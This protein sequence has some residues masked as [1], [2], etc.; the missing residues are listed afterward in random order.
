MGEEPKKK[1]KDTFSMRRYIDYALIVF[2]LFCCCI[3]F[4]FAVYRYRGI[5]AAMGKIMGAL[6]PIIFGLVIAYLINPIMMFVERHVL[7]LLQNKFSTRKKEQKAARVIGTVCAIVIF[8]LIV[9]LLI[10]MM[11]PQ[12]I[13][14]IAGMINTLPE[15]TEAFIKWFDDFTKLET[16]WTD[17]VEKWLVS[18]ATYLEDWAKTSLLPNVQT[19]VGS[20]ASGA[21][22][23]V[24]VLVNFLVGLIVAVYVLMGKEK[25]VG[26]SKKIIY[27]VFKPVRGNIII[28]VVRKSHEIFGGFISGKILDSAIIGVL[29][30]I[31]LSLLHMPYALLVSAFVG[32]T[33][34]IP[35]FGPFIGAIPSV[36]IIALAEPIKGLYF[37]I[38]IL[39]L[40]QLD[41]NVIGPK[42]L[43][44]STGLN[45]FWVVFAIMVGGGLFGFAGMLLGVPTFAVI[46]YLVSR[47]VNYALRKR[48]LSCRTKDYV[49]LQ[50]VDATSNELVYPPRED[51][52]DALQEAEDEL[53]EAE[54][55]VGDPENGASETGERTGES[56]NADASG[57]NKDMD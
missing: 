26:Q 24:K 48:K 5:G 17:M 23:V 35:F 52:V 8:I 29:C 3:L 41:G 53:F 2:V 45:S 16:E 25:F 19:Y 50:S 40:Q 55:R 51:G 46:Y 49:R 31:G 56:G 27:A 33:N 1:T 15:Q 37:V 4:F 18:T 44:D 32:L 7:H 34:V 36:V 30:Y 9:A 28:E 39:A 43:G 13:E 6:Q 54:E 12:L 20:V 22:S 21:I 14:S 47:I 42:I 10:Y 57:Q 11:I 38:F